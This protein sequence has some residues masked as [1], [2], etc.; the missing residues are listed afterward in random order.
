MLTL[1]QIKVSLYRYLEKPKKMRHI[2][3]QLLVS[4]VV[5]MS[6]LLGNSLFVIDMILMTYFTVEIAVRLWIVGLEFRF[7]GAKGRL[8]YLSR[9]VNVI[10]FVVLGATVTCV[11]LSQDHWDSSVVQS[12]RLLQI[13]RC[14]HLDRRSTSTPA[15]DKTNTTAFSNFGDA[16]YWSVVSLLTIGYGDIVPRHWISKLITGLFCLTFVSI[17]TVTSSILGV[18]LA[19]MVQDEQMKKRMGKQAPL[20]AKLIQNYWRYRLMTVSF[21]KI[22]Y[23]RY[24]LM[25]NLFAYELSRIKRN[26]VSNRLPWQEKYFTYS[27]FGTLR[28]NLKRKAKLKALDMIFLKPSESELDRLQSRA[29]KEAS[30]DDREFRDATPSKGIRFQIPLQYDLE[31]SPSVPRE[32]TFDRHG[33]HYILLLRFIWYLKYLVAKR[34]FKEAMKS[35]DLYDISRQL[36]ESENM[37]LQQL[38]VLQSKLEKVLSNRSSVL[39]STEHLETDIAGKVKLIECQMKLLNS[40]VEKMSKLMIQCL[41]TTRQLLV[42]REGNISSANGNTKNNQSCND[43]FACFTHM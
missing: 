1:L 5:V 11:A 22:S 41:S 20:A 21:Q 38:K 23:Y 15:N 18:G 24:D 36:S 25:Q 4:S 29:A 13:L 17:L 28:N 7:C 39:F 2:V 3:Y 37:Q 42:E 34:H 31:N 40:K 43:A 8:R 27:L 9:F 16:L 32:C 33:G 30:D 19:F 14:L 12:V 10:D 6:L 26:P 35:Y